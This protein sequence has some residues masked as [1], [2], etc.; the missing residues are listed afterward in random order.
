MRE[1]VEEIKKR[2]MKRFNALQSEV[3]DDGWRLHWLDLQKFLLNRRG[4][5]LTSRDYEP[6]QGGKMNHEINNGTPEEAVHIAAAGMMG[7]FT[8][9]SIPWFQLI[10]ADEDM[11]EDKR[12]QQYLFRQQS[13]MYEVMNRS[14]W[15]GTLPTMYE[16]LT[17]FGTAAMRLDIHPSRG[18]HCTQ[19]TIGSF[20]LSNG[21]DGFVDT[22]AWR[23]P[24]TVRQLR[25]LYGVEVL[26]P[27]LQTKIKNDELDHYVKCISIVEL[28][29]GRDRSF[30]DWRGM[31]YRS[32]TMEEA[33]SQDDNHKGVLKMG[34]FHTFPTMTPRTSRRAEDVYG[35]SRGMRALPDARQLQINELRGSEALL[36]M[37]RPPLNVPSSKMRS[38][39]A[40]GQQNVYRG[41]DSQAIRP[42]FLTQFPYSE[43][44]DTITALENRLRDTLG[45][46][47]F[48]QFQALDAT[49][50]HNMTVPEVA[51]R[52]AEKM[53]L[54]GPTQQAVHTELLH[55][56]IELMWEHMGTNGQL[57]EPP[58]ELE[59]IELK[60]E[61]VSQLALAERSKIVQGVQIL[62][63][64]IALM[65][66]AF[67]GAADNF[68]FD[69]A[70]GHIRGGSLAPPDV[71]RDPEEVDAIRRDRAAQQQR[72]IE[73]EQ[74]ANES[75]AV[76][77][78]G[79]TPMEGGTALD[80]VA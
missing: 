62:G 21:P 63:D 57:E 37:L 26:S 50:N 24:R 75:A 31:K 11:R 33:G 3:E 9:P 4:R 7:G 14:N 30:A 49:G 17:V 20:Y 25:R 5:Y 53:A 35:S 76:N 66:Q 16:E 23:Y 54:L 44:R 41:S 10:P 77:Q 60:V 12:I 64:Q 42:T 74:L 52:R 38:T 40:A 22:I 32:I 71:I 59:G 1:Q 34:G 72:A 48:Q 65:D 18:V 70:I 69:A 58:T 80:Q 6:R 61:F 2:A 27:A 13:R 46:T 43:S 39:V 36:K 73:Q 28:N 19:H 56:A 8:S 78:L 15:Y 47:V 79:N 67:P 29:E 68:D 55:P 45:T 51:E